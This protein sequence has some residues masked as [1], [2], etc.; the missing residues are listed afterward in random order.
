[1]VIINIVQTIWVQEQLFVDWTSTK[2]WLYNIKYEIA[3]KDCT[4]NLIQQKIRIEKLVAKS[5]KQIDELIKQDCAY[6]Y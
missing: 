3:C 2:S 5:A 4:I 1:M 6:I